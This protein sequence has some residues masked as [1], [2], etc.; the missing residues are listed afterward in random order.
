MDQIKT[1]VFCEGLDL[2]KW[3]DLSATAITDQIHVVGTVNDID[4]AA[5][6]VRLLRPELLLL[7][8]NMASDSVI[9][10]LEQV[11]ES[12]VNAPSSFIFSNGECIWITHCRTVSGKLLTL[13]KESKQQN[14]GLGTEDRIGQ[15]KD[16]NE[17]VPLIQ[18]IGLPNRNGVRYIPTS[19]IVS[20]EAD[21]SYTKVHTTSNEMILACRSLKDFESVLSKD[22]FI[23]V[24]RA[25]IVN[26]EYLEAF[27]KAA[28][29]VLIM[30]NEME[31]PLSRKDKSRIAQEIHIRMKSV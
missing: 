15:M 7:S 13:F 18:K 31:V 6:Q 12:V 19:Q 22:L 28:G 14:P 30:S 25:Y 4:E 20:L 10:M 29:G 16:A 17:N 2:A 23:R 26:L 5:I 21:G 24:H 1:L 11:Q 3:T 8:A 27:N 9:S